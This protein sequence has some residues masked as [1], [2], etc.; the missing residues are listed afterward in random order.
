MAEQTIRDRI[1][2]IQKELRDGALTPDMARESLV[3]LT[4]LYGNVLDELR[5]ADAEYKAVLLQHLNAESK[6]NRARM[7][8]EASP[9]YARVREASDTKNLV[10]EMVRSCKA[11]LRSLEEEMRLAR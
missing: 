8:A 7:H 5:E 10:V 11:Y 9:E 4:A 1:R 2:G 6:A 3:E